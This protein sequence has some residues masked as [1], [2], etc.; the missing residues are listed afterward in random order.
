VPYNG[1]AYVMEEGIIRDYF[2]KDPDKK[3]DQLKIT[4]VSENEIEIFAYQT[5]TSYT[6]FRRR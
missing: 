4:A 2:T 5:K 3:I 1:D 6:L